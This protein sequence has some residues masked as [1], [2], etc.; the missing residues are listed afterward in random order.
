MNM[1]KVKAY[2]LAIELENDLDNG[3]YDQFQTNVDMAAKLQRKLSNYSIVVNS[4]L[5]LN[6]KE[7]EFLRNNLYI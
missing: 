3:I 1:D 2:N 7:R 4:E 5:R 6:F